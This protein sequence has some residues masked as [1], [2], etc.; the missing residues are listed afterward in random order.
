MPAS[1]SS[2]AA[3]VQRAE[4]ALRVVER[5]PQ[6]R[7]DRLDRQRLQDVDLRARQQRRVDLERRV[8][9]RRADQDDVAGL[10]AG[11]EGVLLR[12]VEA[13]DLVDE[14]DRAAARAAARLFRFRHDLADLLDARQHGAERDEV[15]ARRAGDHPRQRRL[16]GARRAPQDDRSQPVVLDRLA[17][18]P[19]R[20]EQ[21]LLADDLVEGARTHPLGE[22]RGR[23]DGVG[24]GLADRWL[25]VGEQIHQACLPRPMRGGIS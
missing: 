16:A 17:Q 1:A 12:L 21:R 10:D 22:R 13:V 14:Q 24:L 3:I 7:H 5:A 4:A 19:S 18:R 2:G 9:G 25:V 11:Q 6:D 15:R 23:I 20:P 8:L